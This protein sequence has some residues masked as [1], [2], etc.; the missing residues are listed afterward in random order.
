MVTQNK[1]RTHEVKYVFSENKFG[2]ALDLIKCLKTDQIREIAPY[3]RL[4][5]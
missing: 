2:T 3:V 1:L 5:F 4:H